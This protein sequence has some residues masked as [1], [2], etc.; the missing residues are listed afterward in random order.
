MTTILLLLALWTPTL[1]AEPANVAGKWNVTL[2]LETITGH[3]TLTLKQEG[4]KV[5]GTYEGRYGASRLE[6]TVKEKKI[7]FT[8]TLVAEGTQTQGVF[9]GTV[10]G[11]TM[12][13]DVAYEG[14]GEGTWT[15]TRTPAKK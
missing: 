14:A 13:G 12:H 9:E 11:D 7:Q 8:V 2:E 3:P 15:A 10:D 5:T 4:E 1:T 6:G